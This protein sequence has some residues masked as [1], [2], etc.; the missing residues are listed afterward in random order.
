MSLPN[1]YNKAMG[2]RS[3]EIDVTDF[4]NMRCRMC[5]R[6]CDLKGPLKREMLSLAD[7]QR[8]IKETI[9]AGWRWNIVK[10]VGGEP[11]LHP[12]IVEI[13]K[14]IKKGKI[15]NNIF[16]FSNDISEKSKELKEIIT[17]L[18]NRYVT[19]L[20]VGGYKSK[21]KLS[22]EHH[23][24]PYIKPSDIGVNYKANV[25]KCTIPFKCGMGFT[26]RG[27]G[28]CCNAVNFMRILG[29]DS[30]LRTLT[31]LLSRKKYIEQMEKYCS[32][33]GI[34]FDIKKEV[35]SEYWI[36]TF[37]ARKIDAGKYEKIQ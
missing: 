15:T 18:V 1:I 31:D 22:Y 21:D 33:C 24:T 8:F 7:I 13:V 26:S 10:V 20:G 6:G 37:K 19:R 11:T 12:D 27:Y 34:P 2:S 23:Y 25:N 4:C 3:I 16:F 35:M 5:V 17:P 9:N 32:I 29:H 36:N 28:I 30:S 14:L